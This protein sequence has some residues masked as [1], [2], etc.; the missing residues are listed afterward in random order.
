MKKYLKNVFNRIANNTSLSNKYIYSN[1]FVVLIPCII[2]AAT[3]FFKFQK[4]VQD[5][6]N[7]S[8]EQVMDQY[9]A[10]INYKLNLFRNIEETFSVNGVV[11]EILMEQDVESPMDIMKLIDKFTKE[12]RS[13]FLGENQEEVYNITLYSYNERL[14][15]DGEFL[16]NIKYVMDE[17]WY[18]D[19]LKTNNFYNCYY[20]TKSLNKQNLLLL[21]QPII[22][23]N[24]SDNSNRLGIIQISLYAN[25]IFRP[26]S[27]M[28]REKGMEIVI[29]DRKGNTVYGDAS[30]AESLQG[31]LK[32]NKSSRV[33]KN[34]EIHKVFIYRSLSPYPLDAIAFFPYNEVNSKVNA[35]ANYSIVMIGVILIISLSLTILFSRVFTKRIHLLIGKMK[36]VEDGNL[37]ITSVIEGEDEIGLLD[38]QF[39]SMTNRLNNVISE[40]YIQRLEKREAELSALQLQINPHFLY[41][42]LES[43]S[44]IAAI[45]NCYDICSISQKLGDM[46]RYNINSIKNEFVH[47]SDEIN[48]IKNY[49]FIQE[50]RFEGRFEVQYDIPETLMNCRI[51]KFVL[52]PIVENA[53]SH[54]LE[55]KAGKGTISITAEVHEN[56]LFL[57]VKDDGVGMSSERVEQLNAYFNQMD[58]RVN[59]R[60]RRSIGLKNVDSRIKMV[61]GN[62]FGITVKSQLDAGTQVVI[63]LPFCKGNREDADV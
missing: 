7:S 4:T 3:F 53:L 23:I 32:D 17:E 1:I 59:E 29:L 60:V 25:R 27:G 56:I 43:I 28:P 26:E 37:N 13:I 39:N 22:Q 16:R 47:L 19:I 61:N 48:H 51:L 18:K 40:N 24:P 50:I 38:R 34:E 30:K 31:L 15:Y 20:E 11:Q 41:N 58:I 5:E 12:T 52:Q 42:T 6:I 62:A 14:S 36:Q 21:S 44:A 63:A 55:G 2:F 45:N 8:Y 35:L 46:F 10:N 57:T 54:G 33:I 9:V 49:I